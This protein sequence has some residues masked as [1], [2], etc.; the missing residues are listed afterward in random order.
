[1]DLAGDVTLPHV[2]RFLVYVRPFRQLLDSFTLN[3]G[4]ATSFETL[5]TL[6]LFS[7]HNP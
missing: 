3:V 2:A 5:V 6:K 7:W 1:V 4:T